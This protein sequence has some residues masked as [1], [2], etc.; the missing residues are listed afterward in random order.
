MRTGQFILLIIVMVLML[1]SINATLREILAEL[2]K[3]N[4]PPP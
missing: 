4:V 1:G 2:R 3:R